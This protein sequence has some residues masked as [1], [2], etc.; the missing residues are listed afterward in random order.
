MSTA[1]VREINPGKQFAGEH[2]VI[3]DGAD[4]SGQ[5]VTSGVYLVQFR[6]GRFQKVMKILL[7]K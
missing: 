7:A 1:T 3:W 4:G 2:A 6:A 5:T